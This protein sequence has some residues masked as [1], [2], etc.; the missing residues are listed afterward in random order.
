[1]PNE[2]FRGAGAVRTVDP[3]PRRPDG[4]DDTM[5]LRA[6]VSGHGR[7]SLRPGV[8]R[9]DGVLHAANG[10]DAHSEALSC[11]GRDASGAG[12]ADGSHFGS[13]GRGAGDFGPGFDVEVPHSGYAWWYIDALSDDGRNALTLIAFIGSVFSPYYAF[14]RRFGSGD[15]AQHCAVNLA[16]YGNHG[17]RWCMTERPRADLMRSPASLA[18]GPSGL[19]WEE[20]RLT[21]SIDERTVPLPRIIKGTVTVTD[22]TPGC[23]SVALDGRGAHLW[24]PVAPHARIHVA[25]EQPLLSW[26]GNAYFDRNWGSEPLERAFR[27]WTWARAHAGRRTHVIYDA[28]RRD[29]ARLSIARQLSE[30]GE[31]KDFEP[32]SEAEL[33]P[34]IVWR[35]PRAMRSCRDAPPRIVKTLED[36][37]FY[38]R[39]LIQSTMEGE[40]LSWIHESLSLDRVSNPVV[41]LMLPFRMPRFKSRPR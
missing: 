36:T 13:A 9:L 30:T 16:L 15:P 39:S 17:K 5:G 6:D 28:E 19:Q 18:I 14:N 29:G 35:M 2:G 10:Q 3:G 8:S 33:P 25:F 41:R 7:G 1:M 22:F 11:G 32:P 21:I 40:R 27:R 23:A 12:G 24:R 26:T 37:P 4:G 31:H 20:G 38:A 34:S